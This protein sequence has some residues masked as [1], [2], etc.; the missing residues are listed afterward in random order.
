MWDIE[1]LTWCFSRNFLGI[2]IYIIY[3][4]RNQDMIKLKQILLE[5]SLDQLKTQFVDTGKITDSEFTEIIGATGG[6]TAYATWLTK[7]VIDKIIN[8]EDLYKYNNHFKIFDRRKREYPFNDINQYKTPED[9]KQ[10]ILKSVEILNT[11]KQD[12]SKQ[13]GITKSNKYQ[14]FYLGSVDGFDVYE[15]PQGRKDLYGASCELGSGTEWCTATGKTRTH[16]D[17]YIKKGP[18]FIFIKPGSDEKYQFSYETTSFQDKN[19]HSII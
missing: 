2:D 6:K 13:K 19:D 4:L 14:E 15:L 5:I 11:E 12:P 16:F 9:I 3:F 7:K 1:L 8:T 18:L 17:K 10:F